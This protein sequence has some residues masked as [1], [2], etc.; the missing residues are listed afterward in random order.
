MRT[1]E[2]VIEY[3]AQEQVALKRSYDAEVHSDNQTYLR[4]Q[5]YMCQRLL[6][7]LEASH[8]DEEEG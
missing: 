6:N 4:G 8:S 3:L 1:I 5:Y 2:E 7:R